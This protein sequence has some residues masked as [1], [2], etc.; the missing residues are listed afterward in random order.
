MPKSCCPMIAI[1]IFSAGC[2]RMPRL[3]F[4]G[5]DLCVAPAQDFFQDFVGVL[6]QGWRPL[7]LRRRCRKLDRHADVVPLAALRM[8][9]FDIHVAPAHVLVVGQILGGHDR[10]AGHV[11]LVQNL[12][13]FALGVIRSE[14]IEQPPNFILVLAAVADLR[15]S[16]I[17]CKFRA[18]HRRD[19]SVWRA[20]P[21]PLPA[22]PRKYSRWGRRACT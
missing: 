15:I 5:R 12:H 16:R 7:D 6:A 19:R 2:A 13:Q 14:L 18:T 4:F 17:G 10:A 20:L 9:E 22:P 21:K 3:A 1:F 8:V 11:E